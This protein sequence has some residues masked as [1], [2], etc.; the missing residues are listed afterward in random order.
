MCSMRTIMLHVKCLGRLEAYSMYGLYFIVLAKLYVMYLD[1]V[2][3][4]FA[5]VH[6]ADC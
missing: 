3:L 1:R 4:M 5:L 2:A 6:R